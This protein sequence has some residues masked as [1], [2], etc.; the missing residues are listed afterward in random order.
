MG[1]HSGVATPLRRFRVA[2]VRAG[3]V[4][5]FLR[6]QNAELM[7]TGNGV[8]TPLP[9]IQPF[10]AGR[11]VKDTCLRMRRGDHESVGRARNNPLACG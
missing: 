10:L 9:G 8:F 1:F 5:S 7:I 6:L 2:R 4:S 11:R 3:S